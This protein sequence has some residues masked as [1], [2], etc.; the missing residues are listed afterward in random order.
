MAATKEAAKSAK[1]KATKTAKKPTKAA[2][3][4]LVVEDRLTG[5]MRLQQLHSKLAEIQVMKGELPMEVSDLEDELEGLETRIQKIHDEINTLKESITGNELKIKE[6]QEHIK[7]YEKQQ[8]NVK[9]NREFDALSKEVELQT[10][11]IA[12]A[13]KKSTESKEAISAKEAYQKESEEA[14]KSKKKDLT[15]KKKE[16]EKIIEETDKEEKALEKL[17]STAEGKVED[18]LLTAYNRIR[19]TYKNGLGV[20]RYDRNACGGCYASIPPQRQLEIRQRKKIVVCEHCGRILVDPELAE[21]T[22]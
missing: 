15:T 13:E 11:E 17:I 7:K 1:K 4:E 3:K 20:V 16:L 2:S 22:S 21:S 10:L 9:N 8:K 12:L 19:G 18:R 5:L 14:I 6:A